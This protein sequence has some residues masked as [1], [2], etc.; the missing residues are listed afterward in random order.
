MFN[1]SRPVTTVMKNV[2]FGVMIV[3]A[4]FTAFNGINSTRSVK[5]FHN[6]SSVIRM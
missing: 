3:F 5:T 4:L 2:I 1:Q 6:E